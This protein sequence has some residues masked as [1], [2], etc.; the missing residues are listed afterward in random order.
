VAVPF[1]DAL[2]TTGTAVGINSYLLVQSIVPGATET[3][4]FVV[5]MVLALNRRPGQG[6]AVFLAAS[7]AQWTLALGVLPWAQLAGGGPSS[8]PLDTRATVEVLLTVSTTLMAVAALSSLVPKRIDSGIVLT[9][10]AIQF[11]F[12]ATG[13]RV[14]IA[15]IFAMFALDILVA[16][17]RSVRPMFASLR[18][19][20]PPPLPPG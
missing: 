7:V 18:S 1:T 16:N 4:E 19:R 8:L 12:P 11:A 3:P 5:A 14:V 17:H 10:F 13:V 9:L 20:H 2:Q 6:L 15:V